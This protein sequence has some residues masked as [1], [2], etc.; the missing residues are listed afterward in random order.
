MQH[1]M[2]IPPI[3]ETITYVKRVKAYYGRLK[4]SQ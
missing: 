1:N 3:N 4:D 2:A